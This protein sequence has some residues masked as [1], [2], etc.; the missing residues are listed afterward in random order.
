MH[1]LSLLLIGLCGALLASAVPAR[2]D[3]LFEEAGAP[4]AIELGGA[5]DAGP[6]DEATPIGGVVR[7]HLVR[8]RA[9]FEAALLSAPGL[10]GKLVFGWSITK[11][12]AVGEGCVMS[13]DFKS[14]LGPKLAPTTEDELFHC[15]SAAVRAWQFPPPAG[16]ETVEV[17]Y[18]FAF[19]QAVAPLL[20]KP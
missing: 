18:P 8:V 1:G 15:I 10:E 9:C 4:L 20:L 17:S 16:G 19:K 5:T 14:D 11:T 13:S 2:A 6:T 3:A 7:E 12:G